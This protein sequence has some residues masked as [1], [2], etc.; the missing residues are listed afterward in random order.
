MEDF[1]R[2]LADD[3]PR[4]NFVWMYD[5]RQQ[6]KILG[7]IWMTI[8]LAIACVIFSMIIGVVGAWLQGARS[9]ILRAVVQGY[10]QFFRNTPPFVQLL[11][12]YFALGQ[13]TPTYAS[14]GWLE[15]P[16]ISNVGWAIVSL[17][18]FA[19]AFNVEIFRAGIE[20]VPESTVEA[21]DS[22][23]FSRLQIYRYVV[24]PLAFRISLPA[25]N[26][27]LVNLVKTTTQAFAIAV[28]EL[29]YQSV[30]IWNDFPSAQNPTML[31]LFTVYIVLVAILVYGMT[32]WERSMRIPGYGG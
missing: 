31:L 8:K 26:N 16:V 14:D 32:K 28:P 5:E 10:I 27:N 25:L 24:L 18:F 4:W 15:E 29:L 2:Q 6:G 22:L 21:A 13:F 9:A 17:S 19:G 23:G 12:F 3:A 11:F 20:A 7:G 30:S 1:F